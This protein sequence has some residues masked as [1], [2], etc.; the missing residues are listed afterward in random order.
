VTT[1]AHLINRC[2]STGKD[3]KTPM[4]VWS[5]KPVD[6]SSLK[7]FGALVYVHI[8]QD[9]LEPRALKCV[10]IGYPEGVKGYKLWE[11]E[12]SGGSKVFIIRDVTYDETRMGMKCKD[13]EN[14]VPETIVEETQF[15]VGLPNEEKD[16]VEDE[17][18]TSDTSGTQL[19]VD[20]DYLLARDRERRTITPPK[21][22]GYADLVCYAL[23][24]AEDV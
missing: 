4:E 22:Y 14:L 19:V 12:S 23:N 13:P 10:F 15:V 3:F 9:K 17:A 20:P 11:L 18:S 5:G 16:D 8:K 1:A 6:Y 21:R 2:P 7:V 24:A